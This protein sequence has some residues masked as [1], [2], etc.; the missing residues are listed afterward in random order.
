MQQIAAT[1]I[2]GEHHTE[3]PFGAGHF[4]R[5]HN[6]IEFRSYDE[7]AAI[8]FLRLAALCQLADGH[9]A[10]AADFEWIRWAQYRILG[11]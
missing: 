1:M 10:A 7:V 11:H 2:I 6:R 3:C 4:Q 9:Q 8:A 5:F